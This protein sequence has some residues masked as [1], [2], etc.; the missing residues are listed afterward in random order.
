MYI[1]SLR[2]KNGMRFEELYQ[3]IRDYDTDRITK[4]ALNLIIQ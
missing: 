2:V 1:D 3:S 4:K